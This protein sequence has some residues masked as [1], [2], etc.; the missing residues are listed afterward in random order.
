MF[1]PFQQMMMD[2]PSN[3]RFAYSR[4]L[5]WHEYDDDGDRVPALVVVC[6]DFLG[7]NVFRMGHEL[8]HMG[9]Y[10]CREDAIDLAVDRCRQE[11]SN[12]ELRQSERD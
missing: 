3:D 12:H 6:D 7:F 5:G 8:E 11:V 9:W 1:N 2:A 4:A 10:L